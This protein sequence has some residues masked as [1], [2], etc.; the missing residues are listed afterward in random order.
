MQISNQHSRESPDPMVSI[1]I[2]HIQQRQNRRSIQELD[3]TM[4]PTPQMLRIQVSQKEDDLITF[5]AFGEQQVPEV[6]G[7]AGNQEKPKR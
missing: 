5:T 6:Q 3:Q 7:T 1:R 2:L 4:L